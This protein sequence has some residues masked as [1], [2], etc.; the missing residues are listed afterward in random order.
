M[1]TL[2]AGG[3]MANSGEAQFQWEIIEAMIS[4]GWN[5]CTAGGYDRKE[6]D[7]NGLELTYYMF[8]KRVR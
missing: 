2:G 8:S 7:V 3:D 4:L 6:G 5:D 1:I